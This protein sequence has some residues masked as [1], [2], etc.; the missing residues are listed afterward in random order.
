LL[1]LTLVAQLLG[2][3]NVAAHSDTT[4]GSWNTPYKEV[5]RAM[6]TD[7]V[8]CRTTIVF[9]KDAVL[10]DALPRVGYR[11]AVERTAPQPP[12]STIGADDCLVELFTFRGSMSSV[13]FQTLFGEFAKLRATFVAT[14]RFG[15]DRF[16]TSKRRFDSDVPDYYVT[17]TLYRGVLNPEELFS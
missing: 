4:K 11:V 9:T 14:R 1:A 17:M 12:S 7:T 3:H 2:I 16:A 8:P 6:R 10:S 15:A 13:D 5:L